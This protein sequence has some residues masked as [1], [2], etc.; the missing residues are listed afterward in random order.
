MDY[1]LCLTVLV[2]LVKE[3]FNEPYLPRKK[4]QP[5]FL[6][7][8]TNITVHRGELAVLRCHI[9]D[10]GPKV[11]VWR[12]ESNDVPLT[13]GTSTFSQEDHMA[14]EVQKISEEESKWDLIIK[15]VQPRHAGTYLCQVTATKLYTHYVT[16]QVLDEPVQI[17][18]TLHLAGTQYL[19]QDEDIKLR[20][21][22]TGS[23]KP[24]SEL[25]WFFNGQRI[26]PS[27]LYWRDRTVIKS[28]VVGNTV[29]SEL[30][31]KRSILEDAGM[32]ICRSSDL[33]IKSISVNVLS[34]EKQTVS[35]R[36]MDSS[37]GR[38]QALNSA[39]S[40]V[41]RHFNIYL[42]FISLCVFTV[43]TS[44]YLTQLS[45]LWQYDHISC[46][47]PEKREKRR[48]GR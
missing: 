7:T 47:S 27:L 14:I 45:F 37:G 34:T 5:K 39:P 15:D 41:Q 33:K 1:V 10:L 2:L 32:Y 44:N 13:I 18:D 48:G 26:M 35:R 20:C 12:K 30:T 28:D 17:N 24:P 31:I 16:L 21:N 4:L 42:S 6:P 19:N 25:E 40:Y 38:I 22:V 3:V 29:Y 36:G 23:L 11:V 46:D 9:V 43:V 8:P